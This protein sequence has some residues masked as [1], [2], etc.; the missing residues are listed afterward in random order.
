MTY[1]GINTTDSKPSQFDCIL[2][3]KACKHDLRT[4]HQRDVEYFCWRGGVKRMENYDASCG[5]FNFIVYVS[6]V[7]A[8]WSFDLVAS[9]LYWSCLNLII[10]P[11]GAKL[12]WESM[13]ISV[14][15]DSCHN[16]GE[17][18]GLNGTMEIGLME[19][20]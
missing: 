11:G 16:F 15:G 7:S 13:G 10:Q 2:P 9:G 18:R 3:R 4:Q 19:I 1:Y 20:G 5:N 6:D 17:T 12:V 14:C 8:C